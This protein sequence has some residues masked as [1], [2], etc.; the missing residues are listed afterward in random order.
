MIEIK[1]DQS[2]NVENKNK[3]ETLKINDAVCIKG[4]KKTKLLTLVKVPFEIEDKTV[5]EYVG[6]FGE[7]IGDLRR[8]TYKDGPLKGLQN[9]NITLKVEVNTNI[10]IPSY[11][12]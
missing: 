9:G 3:M 1:Y 5:L 6:K 7:V 11:H 4:F 2:F 10:N 8:S 12:S